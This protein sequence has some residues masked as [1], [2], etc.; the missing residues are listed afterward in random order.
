ME[1]LVAAGRDRNCIDE[2]GQQIVATANSL[3]I[4]VCS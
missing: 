3:E 4:V 1:L 2:T